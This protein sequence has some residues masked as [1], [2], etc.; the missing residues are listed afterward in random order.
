MMSHFF[1]GTTTQ[2]IVVTTA[3]AEN[4]KKCSSREDFHVRLMKVLSPFSCIGCATGSLNLDKAFFKLEKSLSFEFNSLSLNQVDS[5]L[6]LGC[7]VLFTCVA[8]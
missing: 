7:R 3:I 8:L 4:R 1:C 5:I 6:Q 2:C